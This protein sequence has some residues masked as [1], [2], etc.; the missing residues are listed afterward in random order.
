MKRLFDIVVSLLLIIVL[1]PL[2]LFICLVVLIDAGRPV[3]FRQYRVGRGNKLFY[4]YKF[5]TMKNSTRNVA[6]K[7]L[8]NSNKCITV[9]GKIL[10]KMS[11]D[12]LPQLFNILK[13]D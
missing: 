5:R 10:R 11:L 4:I 3:I 12:E 2:E 7:K 9:S 1:L 8:R 13:G 6:T